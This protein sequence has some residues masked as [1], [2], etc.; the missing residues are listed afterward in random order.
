MTHAK[1]YTTKLIHIKKTA[2][3]VAGFQ[4]LIMDQLV[5]YQPIHPGK[6]IWNTKMEVDGSDDFPDFKWVIFS[7]KMS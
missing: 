5:F 4:H 6:I 3:E 2:L 7:F 1:N